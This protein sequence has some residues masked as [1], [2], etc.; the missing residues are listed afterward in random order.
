MKKTLCTVLFL[1]LGIVFLG[2]QTEATVP[3]VLTASGCGKTKNEA[4]EDALSS[5]AS[6]VYA[7]IE[8]TVQSTVLESEKKGKT[9]EN[10]THFSSAITVRTDVPL[11]GVTF[12]KEKKVRDDFYEVTAFL[13]STTVNPLYKAELDKVSQKLEASFS[14]LEDSVTRTNAATWY[15][16]YERLVCVA[17]LLKINDI[18]TLSMNQRDFTAQLQKHAGTA[19]SIKSAA[20]TIVSNI[21]QNKIYVYPVKYHGTDGVSPFAYELQQYIASALGNSL[22]D[23]EKQASYFLSGT[24]F[25]GK[26]TEDGQ[27]IDVLYKLVSK[28]SSV[29]T[30][31]PIV[32]IL[33]VALEG[34]PYIPKC[35]DFQNELAESD[36][37]AENTLFADICINGRK[38]AL[39]FSDGNE[40]FIDVKVSEPCYI[41]IVG[42][43]FSDDESSEPFAYLYPFD[44]TKNGKEKFVKKIQPGEDNHWICI[45]PCDYGSTTPIPIEII[46]PYGAEILHMFAATEHDLQSFLNRIPDYYE[47][48]EYYVVGKD[49]SDALST[50][51]GLN[52]KKKATKA[53]ST[54]PV[55]SY[56]TQITFT[57]HK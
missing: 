47:T 5:L 4:R 41:Y 37:Q 42:Y 12:S 31:S 45:N 43:V 19:T 8:S 13:N 39:T 55:Q 46:S 51:R 10:E 7:H 16:E 3:I 2:A 30:T 6:M 57:S 34:K 20:A 53:V 40:V 29:I 15:E 21:T 52:T 26:K 49:P 28:N 1:L 18:P 11:F 25:E 36:I 32:S 27:C 17:T 33:P 50:T 54:I 38:D 35:Y 44:E 48:S 24:C 22:C 56:E 14:S 9:I 23:S